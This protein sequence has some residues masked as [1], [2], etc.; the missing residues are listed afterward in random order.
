MGSD[1]GQRAART[2][3]VVSILNGIDGVKDIERD[4]KPGKEQITVDLD[5]IRLAQ[6]ELSVADV[7]KT[8]RLAY[9]GEVVT[10]VRYGDEDVDFRV[11]LEE[12]ARGSAAVL[13]QLIIP[14]ASGR[15]ISLDEVADFN[16]G[17]GPSNSY[18]FNNEPAITC[19]A[20][21]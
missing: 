3:L 8:I 10:S 12:E 7:A 16:V 2:G 21:F 9:D 19:H 6:N 1:E 17:P 5:Y 20:V 18:H 13:G 15:F 14:N 11:I 4:D